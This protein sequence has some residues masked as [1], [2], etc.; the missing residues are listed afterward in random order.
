[1]H[2]CPPQSPHSAPPAPQAFC[3][4]P[5]VQVVVSL[6]QPPSHD[7]VVQTHW[8]STHSSPGA[9][10]PP[11]PQPQWPFVQ[12]SAAVPQFVHDWPALPH[13]PA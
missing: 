1:L 6:Q 3:A 10:G 13:A 8:L 2:A 5:G 12:V 9:H 4:V 11:A 7:A